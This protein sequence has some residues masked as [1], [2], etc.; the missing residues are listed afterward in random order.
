ML[1][2]IAELMMSAVGGPPTTIV[3]FSSGLTPP[4]PTVFYRGGQPTRLCPIRVEDYD[5][6][7][8]VADIA[9]VYLYV[10]YVFDDTAIATMT[11]T[12]EM[13]SGLENLAGAASAELIR[14][15]ASRKTAFAK[16]ARETSAYYL[17]GFEASDSERMGAAVRVDLRT[18]RSGVKLRGR[19]K[20]VIPNANARASGSEPKTAGELLRSVRTYRDLALKADAFVSRESNGNGK[21]VVLFEPIER[22]LA[23]KDAAIGLFDGTG[24]LTAQS[25]PDG[26]ELKQVPVMNALTAKNGSYRLRVA[27]TDA[28]GRLGTI[29]L[30]VSTVLTQ[31]GPMTM[32]SMVI[33]PLPSESFVP[34]LEFASEPAVACYFELYG[35]PKNGI[36]EAR[37]ELAQSVDGPPLAGLQG[38]IRTGVTSNS[39]I[40]SAPMRITDIPPGDTLVRAIVLL[41]GKE[42]GRVVRTLRKAGR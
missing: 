29:D 10:V 41:D 11:S 40:V 2:Q 19:S 33:G 26:E 22:G 18:S 24:R 5:E 37:F 20:V 15:N 8:Q 6:V 30:D 28:A 32:S 27:A 16:V 1:R 38:T 39:R 25:T 35:V 4:D 42:V 7:T 34:R 13:V 31:G 14:P 9:P 12:S 3:L 21:V 17:L 36:L 23:L